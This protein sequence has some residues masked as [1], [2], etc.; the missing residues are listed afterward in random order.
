M[1]KSFR[2]NKGFTLVE[3]LIAMALLGMVMLF[4]T[5]TIA[6]LP[7]A[8]EKTDNMLMDITDNVMITMQLQEVFM[9]GNALRTDGD[10]VIVVTPE[11][12]ICISIENNTLFIDNSVVAPLLKGDMHKIGNGVSFDLTLPN[13]SFIQTTFYINEGGFYEKNSLE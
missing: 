11:E 10:R 7:D 1:L 4:V 3:T 8:S 2:K 13:K 5:K 9:Q 6:L 12:E